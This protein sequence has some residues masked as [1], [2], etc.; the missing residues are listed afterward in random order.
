MYMALPKGIPT[1]ESMVTKNWTHPDNVFCSG[2]LRDKLV[3]CTTD[4]RLCGPCT[5]HVPIQTALEFPLA[6]VPDEMGHNFRAIDWEVFL[7]NLEA[8]LETIAG[9]APIGLEDRFDEAMSELMEALQG[10]ICETVPWLRS[11]PHSK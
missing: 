9:P 4:P 5:D 10:T 2:N 7:K 6:R 8:K 1:V 11:S 3:Y